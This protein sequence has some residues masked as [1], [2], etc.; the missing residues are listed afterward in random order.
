MAE[1]S[2][3]FFIC[4]KEAAKIDFSSGEQSISGA[5]ARAGEGV[6]LSGSR[7]G[8]EEQKSTSVCVGSRC[9]KEAEEGRGRRVV[10]A[11]PRR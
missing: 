2:S 9:C 6:T 3:I 7:G 8:L 4:F 1:G 10:A 5:A 11:M